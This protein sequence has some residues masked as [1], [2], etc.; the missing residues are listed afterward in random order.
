VSGTVL[1]LRPRPGAD[2][3]AAQARALGL[4]PAVAPLFTVRP[5]A[6][7]PPDPGGFE[8][9]MLTSANA[10]RHGGAALSRYFGLPCYTVG[11]PTAAAAREAGF[12]DIRVGAGDGAALLAAMVADGVGRALHLCG[13]DRHA[14]DR[15]GLTID[16]VA[17]YAA[18]PVSRLPAEAEAA[19]GQSALVLLHSP[20]AA[21]LFRT[22]VGDRRNA[23]DIAAI[24]PAA[25]A[26][27]GEGW[28]SVAVA[29]RPRGDALLEL[30][31]KLCQT[32]AR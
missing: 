4:R 21:S 29:S 7:T 28:R 14:L 8:A 12:G 2:D 10:A 15:P 27:A 31:A 11:E 26:A 18:D 20:R 24:S 25:A 22:L 5:I 30:A 16:S 32:A 9:A 19:I 6:W 1:I 13:R 3:S 23:L 17:V